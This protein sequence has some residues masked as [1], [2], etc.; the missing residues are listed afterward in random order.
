MAW[1]DYE[2]HDGKRRRLLKAILARTLDEMW[3][4]FASSDLKPGDLYGRVRGWTRTVGSK[5]LFACGFTQ[6]RID[7][8]DQRF[9][10]LA[11]SET[12]IEHI[13]GVARPRSATSA[14]ALFGTSRRTGA[15]GKAT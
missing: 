1:L 10:H 4:D 15:A 2:P 9:T 3:S 7:K 12:Q 5:K 13:D 14:R 6:R 11:L 8:E